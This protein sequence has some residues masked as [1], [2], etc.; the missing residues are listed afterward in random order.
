VTVAVETAVISPLLFT[1]I[2]GTVEDPPKVPGF[3][4]TVA[5]VVVVV[6]AVVET[7]PDNAG[8]RAE[9]NTPELISD[10]S[11]LLFVR[12]WVSEVPTTVPVGAGMEVVT[13]GAVRT[14]MPFDPGSANPA[15]GVSSVHVLVAVHA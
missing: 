2:I 14:T 3:A 6:P 1:V 8:M 15:V 12:V 4:F 9:E 5:S 11:M 13:F 10:A 7:S